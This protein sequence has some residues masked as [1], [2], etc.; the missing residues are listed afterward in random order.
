MKHTPGQ[1]QVRPD[2]G[3]ENVYRLWDKDSNYH[4]RTDPETMDANAILM[5]SAPLLLEALRECVTD[6]GAYCM[7]RDEVANLK[8][9]LA[10]INAVA[11]LAS[12]T[13]RGKV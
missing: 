1:W 4:K 6:E 3:K 10:S 7:S 11:K 13:A 5:Q 12:A 8:M 2:Y 9:R